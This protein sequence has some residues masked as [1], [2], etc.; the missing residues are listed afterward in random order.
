MNFDEICSTLPIFFRALG[1]D[2]G[3]KVVPSSAFEKKSQRNWLQ[4]IS[5]TGKR[6]ELSW[7]DAE[8]LRLPSFIDV[9][10]QRVFNRQLYLWLAMLQTVP[11]KNGN[12]LMDCANR[13]QLALENAPGFR[14]RYNQLVEQYLKLRPTPSTL[15]TQQAQLEISIQKTL[16]HPENPAMWKNSDRPPHPVMMW[17]DPEPPV[18][19]YLKLRDDTTDNHKSSLPK[20]QQQDKKRRKGKVIDNPDG[21]DGLMLFRF[22]SIF[23][24]AEFVNVNRGIDDDDNDDA[25]RNVDDMEELAVTR[26]DAGSGSLKLDLDLPMEEARRIAATEA[27]LL[28]EWDYRINR[29][30]ANNCCVFEDNPPLSGTCEL[31]EHLKKLSTQVK[32]QFASLLPQRTWLRQQIDGDEI[33][34]DAWHQFHTEVNSSANVPEPLLYRQ[35]RANH[36]DL[37]CVLL[38]DLSLSTDAWIN[39]EKRVIDVIRDALYLFAESLDLIGDRFSICGFWSKRN[40]LVNFLRI[41]NFNEK[42]NPQVRQKISNLEPGYYTRMGAAIRHASKLLAEESTS[43]RLILLLTDGKPNDL[44]LY[45]GRYGVEDTRRAILEARKKGLIPFCI[46]IDHQAEDYLPHIFGTGSYAVIQKAE[47]LPRRLPLLYAKLTHL[48]Q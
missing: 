13:S 16:R 17:P 12:W 41:K 11:S 30:V 34:L 4:K 35:L 42:H 1:G 2:S 32:K 9:F 43:Q 37:S 45:E 25:L 47:D 10:P 19:P 7:Q 6:F 44:D 39:N 14:A 33:D 38:A 20:Q 18:I 36:R 8:A 31:P 27:I 3:K 5:G 29:L 24:H 28:P 22:E 40:E 21:R 26:A 48:G 15:N 23:S 46:T